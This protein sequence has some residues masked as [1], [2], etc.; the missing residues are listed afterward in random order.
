MAATSSPIQ[1]GA[2]LTSFPRSSLIRAAQ[3]PRENLSSGP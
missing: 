2:S 1:S 3:G